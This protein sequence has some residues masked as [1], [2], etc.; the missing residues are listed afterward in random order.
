MKHI[1]TYEG[2]SN[3]FKK[4]K[5]I[6]EIKIYHYDNGQKE[7]EYHLLKNGN[8]HREDGPAYRGWNYNGQIWVEQYFING[9]FH[10]EDGPAI[11]KWDNGQ[12][13]EEYYYLNN[14]EYTREEW[15]EQL[16]KIGSP[17]YEDQLMKYQA[18]KYNM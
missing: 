18:E 10:R 5:E 17:H 9:K 4:N 3:F 16:K 1:K 12:L 11:Q 14:K 6:P 15:L 13:E 7:H 2:L 8:L